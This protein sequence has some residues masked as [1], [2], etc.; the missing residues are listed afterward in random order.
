MA[1]SVVPGS[2]SMFSSPFFTARVKWPNPDLGYRRVN[3]VCDFHIQRA[4]TKQRAGR[5][6][7][8]VG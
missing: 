7:L 1:R 5:A 2:T 8:F 3:E 4:V 6:E